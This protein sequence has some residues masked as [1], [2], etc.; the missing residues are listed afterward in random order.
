M[1]FIDTN[2]YTQN[3]EGIQNINTKKSLCIDIGN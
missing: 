2:I 3:V 1:L